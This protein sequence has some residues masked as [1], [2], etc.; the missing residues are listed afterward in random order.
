MRDV[1]KQVR[2]LHQK[3]VWDQVLKQIWDQVY[4]PGFEPVTPIKFNILDQV[5]NQLKQKGMR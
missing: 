4:I 2:N 5:F 3:Q 1:L